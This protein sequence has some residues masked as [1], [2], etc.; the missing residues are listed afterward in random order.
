LA[1]LVSL[2]ALLLV[3]IREQRGGDV[4]RAHADRPDAGTD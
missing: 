2:S 1:L 3:E 4:D